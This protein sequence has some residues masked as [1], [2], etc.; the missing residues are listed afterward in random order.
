MEKRW[1]NFS[2]KF[3]KIRENP[4]P[5]PLKPEKLEKNARERKFVAKIGLRILVGM[6]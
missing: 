6:V 1:K 5:E 3:D 4:P 2:T